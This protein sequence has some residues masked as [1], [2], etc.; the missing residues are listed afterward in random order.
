[1]DIKRIF[2]SDRKTIV[3]NNTIKQLQLLFF[4]LVAIVMSVSSA[5]SQKSSYLPS[6]VIKDI[7]LDWSTHKRGAQGSDNF[8]L[9]WADDNNLYGAWG[10][11][12]GFVANDNDS[13]RVRLGVAR[14]E[15]SGKSWSGYDVWGHSECVEN[16]A[17]F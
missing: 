4:V 16:E 11:G 5:Y 8:Q 12:G 9:T 10:D 2:F 1:M 7:V 3:R 15:G 17:D 13:C 14:I 6:P